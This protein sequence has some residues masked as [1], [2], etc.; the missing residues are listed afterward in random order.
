VVAGHADDVE[1]LLAHALGQPFDGRD[2]V[3][4]MDGVQV[5]STRT[6]LTGTSP[7]PGR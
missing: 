1:A 3:A 2:G 6:D 7:G 5:Q 4:G